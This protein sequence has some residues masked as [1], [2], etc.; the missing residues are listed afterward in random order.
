PAAGKPPPPRRTGQAGGVAEDVLGSLDE[1][2]AL[3]GSTSTY[4][5]LGPRIIRGWAVKLVLMAALFPF[6][7]A[8]G[9]L[10]ARGR[11]RGTPLAPALRS[12]RSRLAFWLW[13]GGLFGLM[14]LLGIW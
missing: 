3:P 5:Y 9:D 2:A 14:T 8:A 4:I 12:Y 6:L 1:G 13:T 10:F 7:L 11:R